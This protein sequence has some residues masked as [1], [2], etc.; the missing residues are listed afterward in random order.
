MANYA[1]ESDLRELGMS[2]AEAERDWQ[3]ELENPL[4]RKELEAEMLRGGNSI[5][6]EALQ[7]Y[8]KQMYGAGA[9]RP[10]P[11][12][13]IPIDSP[14]ALLSQS[15]DKRGALS[16][17]ANVTPQPPA[18][19]VE[20]TGA[21][22]R[23]APMRQQREEVDFE[24]M[25]AKYVPQD[26]SKSRYLALAAALSAPT[27]S[28]TFGETM[29]NVANAMLQQKQQQQKLRAQYAPLVMQQI[30]AQQT[31]EEQNAYRLEAQMQAQ[32]AQR[33][34][35]IA[36]QQGRVELAGFNQAAANERAKEQRAFQ[37]RM[38][39]RDETLRRDLAGNSDQLRRDL[40]PSKDPGS[41]PLPANA[42]KMQQEA[43]DAIGTSSSINADLSAL[44]KQIETG[45][46]N[47]G[48]VSN[49]IN[50]GRNT[51]G[52]STEES[53][54]FGSANATLERLRNESLRLNAGVQ[55][56]GDAQR[57]WSELIQNVNDTDFVK[58]RLKEIQNINKRGAELQ[59]LKIDGVRANYGHEPL[60]TSAQ[61]NV[62]PALNTAPAAGGGWSIKPKG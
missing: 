47:F 4:M 28:G 55:T 31:R 50:K 44:E 10:A 2:P 45:K 56:D 25:L 38:Q 37:E 22:S 59:Q 19:P 9:A 8:H 53:R 27:Q 43:L 36:Q 3:Y 5:Q 46:L 21:L 42:L 51:L 29:N 24:G 14:E 6:R 17:A 54:N 16:V 40:S 60:D 1:K 49:L 57:A 58:Q 13:G 41:K 33:Q 15:A 48:P 32:E 52:A 20:Q 26:D 62:P 18:A 34:A 61:R 23:V 35:L 39:G 11:A 7:S 30:A 12:A